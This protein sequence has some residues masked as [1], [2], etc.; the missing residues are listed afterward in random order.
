[1]MDDKINEIFKSA[2]EG[3]EMPYNANAWK[4]FERKLEVKKIPK[5]SNLWKWLTGTAALVAIIGGSLYLNSTQQATSVEKN[6]PA[7][8]SNNKKTEIISLEV[9]GTEAKEQIAKKE[10]KNNSLLTLLQEEIPTIASVIINLNEE[11]TLKSN[12]VNN[13]LE[14][15]SSNNDYN[16]A[17][18]QVFYPEIEINCLN[19]EQMIENKNSFNLLLQTP[20]G[21]EIVLLANQKTS[22][23]AKT[24]GTY[25]IGWYSEPNNFNVYKSKYINDV[26]ALDVLTEELNY[27]NGLPT[28]PVKFRTNEEEVV[29]Q[30]DNRSITSNSN[31]QNIYLFEKGDIQIRFT[32]SNIHSCKTTVVKEISVNEN[33]N[34]LAVN[35]F[36]PYSSDN[37]KNSFMPFALTK[38]TSPFILVIIDPADGGVVFQSNDASNSWDGYD[39]RNGKMVAQNKAFIW[40]VSLQNPEKKEKSDYK[41]TIIRL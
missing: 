9:K 12:L 10:I 7:I 28:L 3:H 11:G 27:D 25:K 17:D 32:A 14:T 34:L 19:E 29:T 21:E 4:A 13:E 36:D 6:I 1:M 35:A 41:G 39:K 37:R 5:K 38:R 30:Y 40:K 22:I 8:H 31:E 23:T 16:L 33:Y 15:N 18:Q 26:P 24:K 2:L 20:T